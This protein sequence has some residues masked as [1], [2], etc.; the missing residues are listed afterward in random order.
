[1]ALKTKYYLDGNDRLW[2]K[3]ADVEYFFS[4][5]EFE[6]VKCEIV[7]I[8]PHWEFDFRIDAKDAKK[9]LSI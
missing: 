4:R 2:R 6:W 7:Y 3:N 1:M 8:W 9:L 5:K